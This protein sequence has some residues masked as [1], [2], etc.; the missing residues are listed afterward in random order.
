MTIQTIPGIAK[1]PFFLMTEKGEVVQGGYPA[2]ATGRNNPQTEKM[3][4]M[5]VST[6]INNRNERPDWQII[7]RNR[8]LI[9]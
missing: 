5:D 8:S 6:L 9:R 3:N 4:I 1:P 2:M 7:N